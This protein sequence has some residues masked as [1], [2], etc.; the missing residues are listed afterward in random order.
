MHTIETIFLSGCV[1]EAYQQLGEALAMVHEQVP[2]QNWAT[3]CMKADAIMPMSR[4]H[5]QRHCKIAV[6]GYICNLRRRMVYQQA[7]NRR[8]A[9]VIG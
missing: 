1:F 5:K 2:L 8:A 4:M 7:R 9:P 3:Y 6:Q